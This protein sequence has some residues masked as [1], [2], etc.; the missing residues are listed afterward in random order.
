MRN[1]VNIQ[2]TELYFLRGWLILYI[3]YI[4]IKIF[5]SKWSFVPKLL[6][7]ICLSTWTFKALP[8]RSQKCRHFQWAGEAKK[9]F[10]SLGS[11]GLPMPGV[12]QHSPGPDQATF[13][14]TIILLFLWQ[15]LLA[16]FWDPRR[17][18]FVRNALVMWNSRLEIL[19][20]SLLHG[21][22]ISD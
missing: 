22:M 7:D 17:H 2:T 11:P 4:S 18:P 13:L 6:D 3:N 15:V 20:C 16:L 10:W 12:C 8:Q 19:K 9:T 21:K 14:L 1:P 5:K